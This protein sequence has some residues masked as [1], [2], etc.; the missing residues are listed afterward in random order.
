[1]LKRLDKISSMVKQMKR[2]YLTVTY[3]DG[4][5]KT[6]KLP[7]FLKQLGKD[8]KIIMDVQSEGEL[9]K[10]EQMLPEWT[11]ALSEGENYAETS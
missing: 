11:Q 10:L 1:M 5:T 3:S 6:G 4:S 9:N 8:G 2:D 7:Y